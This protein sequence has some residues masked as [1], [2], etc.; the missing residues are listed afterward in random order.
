VAP[1]LIVRNGMDGLMLADLVRR[2]VSEDESPPRARIASLLAL[3]SGILLLLALLLA[4]FVPEQLT[5]AL[6]LYGLCAATASLASTA[7]LRGERGLIP[8][9]ALLVAG[10]SAALLIFVTGVGVLSSWLIRISMPN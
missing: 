8:L 2:I 7:I 3:G 6:P 1:A 10:S 4:T 9:L 5:N